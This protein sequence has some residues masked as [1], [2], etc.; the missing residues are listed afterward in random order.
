MVSVSQPALAPQCS[1]YVNLFP[2]VATPAYMCDADARRLSTNW[3]ANGDTN[4]FQFLFNPL[5]VFVSFSM[6]M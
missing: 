4:A 3:H 1:V 5:S 6:C 2:F